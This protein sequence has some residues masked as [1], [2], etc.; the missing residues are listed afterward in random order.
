M[1]EDCQ[2]L[3][4][5]G[6][7]R[8]TQK[9][10]PNTSWDGTMQQTQLPAS[11]SNSLF[12]TNLESLIL[13]EK[14]PAVTF[15]HRRPPHC[16]GNYHSCISDHLIAV[17][18]TTPAPAAI[19]LQKQLLVLHQQ[20]PVLLQRP[21][22]CTNR[23]QRPLSCTSRHKQL[24]VLHQQP[25]SCTSGHFPAAVDISVHFP[26]PAD[27]SSCQSCTSDY[28]TWTSDQ[29]PAPADA[30]NYQSWTSD[31]FPAPAT[32][33]PEPVTTFLHQQIPAITSSG[34]ANTFLHQQIP[35]LNQWPPIQRIPVLYQL[36]RPAPATRSCSNDHHLAAVIVRRTLFRFTIHHNKIWHF[37]E[38]PC[39]VILA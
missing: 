31:H 11:Q 13:F 28:Q 9:V 16:S 8:P 17:A 3:S 1:Q 25:P 15:L 12:R 35:A 4:L 34:P 14:A 22:S 24:P 7:F 38:N 5:K 26:A 21:P 10:F 20:L 18:T 2:P 36:S 37:Q 29:F 23:H 19:S 27:T 6:L 32:N 33:S 30:S 39:F